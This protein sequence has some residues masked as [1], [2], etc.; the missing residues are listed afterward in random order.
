MLPVDAFVSQRGCL[1]TCSLR[2]KTKKLSEKRSEF[3]ILLNCIVQF[4]RNCNLTYSILIQLNY[5]PNPNPTHNS[6]LLM[7]SFFSLDNFCVCG[8]K[9]ESSPVFLFSPRKRVIPIV[10]VIFMSK[11]LFFF[12][13]SLC[14]G[15]EDEIC[16]HQSGSESI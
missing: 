14:F 12:F 6:I 8:K 5:F 11:Q 9:K 10:L 1:R 3:S 15:I 13:F 16:F 7:K 4:K 2:T